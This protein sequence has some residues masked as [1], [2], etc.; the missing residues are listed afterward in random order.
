MSPYHI[1]RLGLLSALMGGCLVGTAVGAESGAGIEARLRPEWVV[2]NWRGEKESL[3]LQADGAFNALL[4]PTPI[5]GPTQFQIHAGGA[6]TWWLQSN[7]GDANK[8]TLRTKDWELELRHG[9]AT[10]AILVWDPVGCWERPLHRVGKMADM[11]VTEGLAE[12]ETAE[13]ATEA[14]DLKAADQAAGRA[15]RKL[16]ELSEFCPL[17]EAAAAFLRARIREAMGRKDEAL[18]WFE[19][20]IRLR[21]G[22][23]EAPHP[24]LTR[25]HFFAGQAAESQGGYE[26]SL[27]YFA[28]AL[29]CQFDVWERAEAGRDLPPTV[30]RA[31]R[32]EMAAVCFETGRAC[33]SFGFTRAVVAV[34]PA[35]ARLARLNGDPVLEQGAAVEL[36]NHLMAREKVHDHS[37]LLLSAASY[38]NHL[39]A[40]AESLTPDDLRGRVLREARVAR[41]LN[42]LNPP[43]S[44]L[45]RRVA[46][47]AAA[48]GLV[49]NWSQ[50]PYVPKQILPSLAADLGLTNEFAR[51]PKPPPA[52][53]KV[54]PFPLSRAELAAYLDRVAPAVDLAKALPELRLEPEHFPAGAPELGPVV[55]QLKKMQPQLR[56]MGKRPG[57]A[58]LALKIRE[59]LAKEGQ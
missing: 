54:A 13:R 14:G 30:L 25:A 23:Y 36:F 45:A 4:F 49:S 37:G 6:D 12:L 56:A 3:R 16:R 1:G 38:L 52:L 17:P 50:A 34:F 27:G 42:A 40:S 21:V 18:M 9:A 46:L 24:Q 59:L 19:E 2:G 28:E 20:C 44:D 55:Q 22:G 48:A 53:A 8:F 47:R 57:A 35:A 51:L 58:E 26:R 15:L 41:E 32:A 31:V 7:P 33:S 10:N 5:D 29:A 43:R 39:H 11:R